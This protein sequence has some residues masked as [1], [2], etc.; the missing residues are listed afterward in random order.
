M[1]EC[2]L[3]SDSRKCSEMSEH[4]KYVI[5]YMFYANNGE[6]VVD[7]EWKKTG[8]RKISWSALSIENVKCNQSLN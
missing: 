6:E 3:Y 2:V 1:E 8:G 4:G 5:K 7:L